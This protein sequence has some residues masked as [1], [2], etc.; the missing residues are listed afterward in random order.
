MEEDHKKERQML[1]GMHLSADLWK[2]DEVEDSDL[3][4]GWDR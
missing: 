1:F 2:R 4:D 3:W